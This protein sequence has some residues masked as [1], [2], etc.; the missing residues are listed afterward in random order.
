M[1]TEQVSYSQ[2]RSDLDEIISRLQSEETSIDQ[3]LDLYEKGVMLVGQLKD[4]LS[5]SQNR[6]IKISKALEEDL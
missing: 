5:K 2:L 6:L 3:A 4:Y 1:A